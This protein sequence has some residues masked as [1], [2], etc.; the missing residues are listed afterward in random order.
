M[1]RR[2]LMI[3][4]MAALLLAASGAA[5]DVT[6]LSH[7]RTINAESY[8]LYFDGMDAIVDSDGDSASAPGAGAWSDTV[9]VH[10]VADILYADASAEQDSLISTQ[11][12]SGYGYGDYDLDANSSMSDAEAQAESSYDVQFRVT[13]NQAY[14][15]DVTMAAWNDGWGLTFV[16][17]ELWD[18]N[19]TESY[20]SQWHE[21]SEE[22]WTTSGMLP[23]GDYGLTMYAYASGL[24]H[25][26][27]DT[28]WAWFDF[29]FKV[30]AP[31]SAG[32]LFGG[33]MLTRRRGPV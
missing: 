15:L 21:A 1:E 2:T 14:D 10:A 32:L 27:T 24:V 6:I 23:P 9:I 28:G 19:T 17:A 13:S 11:V 8:V 33:L 31:G 16:Y 5:G 3:G 4:G 29:T 25:V 30:P 20:F 12:L 7:G 26:D 22:T 18:I